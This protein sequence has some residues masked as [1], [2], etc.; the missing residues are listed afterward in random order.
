M[1][2]TL[3]IA[4]DYQIAPR[5]MALVVSVPAGLGF[6][7]PIGTPANAIAYSSGFLTIRDMMVPGAI[8]SVS[9]W[10]VFNLVAW[11]YWPLLGIHI[12]SLP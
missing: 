1:P 5:V 12:G 2:L 7:L 10:I 9:S 11:Y 6:T 8:L 3:G 4:A